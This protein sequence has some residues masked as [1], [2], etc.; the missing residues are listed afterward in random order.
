MGR[1]DQ[2]DRFNTG[3]LNWGLVDFDSL[4]DMVKVLSFGAKKYSPH[5]WRKGL[6]TTEI[7][8]SLIR[9]LQAY[10]RGEDL[11]PESGLSH[12]GHIQCNAM[13]LAYMNRYKPEF[14]NRY[15]DLNKLKH[16]P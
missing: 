9:H 5:N 8:E 13:F 16:R 10:L 1:V 2:A 6:G 3:K 11:D 4:E 15:K 12:I 14:D 7:C